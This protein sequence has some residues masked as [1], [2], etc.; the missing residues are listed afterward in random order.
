MN[1]RST[2]KERNTKSF[3]T[4][5]RSPRTSI[6]FFESHRTK[7]ESVEK[8][9]EMFLQAVRT[10]RPRQLPNTGVAGSGRRKT[11]WNVLA[12]WTS[13]ESVRWDMRVAA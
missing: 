4:T 6:D 10:G 2:S 11:A 9:A 8:L 5:A 13:A 3:S 12:L 7:G 1:L